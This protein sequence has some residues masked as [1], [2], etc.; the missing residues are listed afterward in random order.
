MTAPRED[1]ED[2]GC[3][4]TEICAGWLSHI[5]AS[6]RISADREGSDRYMSMSVPERDAAAGARP[7]G[8]AGKAATRRVPCD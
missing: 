1:D 4:D 8:I 2:N 5:T 3:S 6:P 7:G